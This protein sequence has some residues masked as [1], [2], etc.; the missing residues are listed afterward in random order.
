MK[1][2][3]NNVVCYH[4]HFSS[5]R[6]GVLLNSIVKKIKICQWHNTGRTLWRTS[7]QPL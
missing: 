6:V 3:Y 2:Y 7:R 1:H 4:A 5:F